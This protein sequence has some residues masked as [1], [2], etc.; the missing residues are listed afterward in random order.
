MCIRD[1]NQR[2]V[3]H[4]STDNSDQV[5]WFVETDGKIKCGYKEGGTSKIT[6]STFALADG[7]TAWWHLAAV[8]DFSGTG[9]MRLFTNGAA[10]V[11]YTLQQS[12]AGIDPANYGNANRFHVG[13]WFQTGT[14]RGK[15]VRGIIDDFRIFTNALSAADVAALYNAGSGTEADAS[16]TGGNM[17]LQSTNGIY[18]AANVATNRLLLLVQDDDLDLTVGTD[19]LADVSNDGSTWAAVDMADQEPYSAGVRVWGGDAPPGGTGSNLMYR[20][21]TANLK[22][23]ELQGAVLMVR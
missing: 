7:P 2:I 4:F 13:C 1:S 18:A 3:G 11:A 17:L 16:M 9:T 22:D 19:V 12:L 23:G 21:R 20:V 6:V 15:F 5:D 10:V 14:T 8:W